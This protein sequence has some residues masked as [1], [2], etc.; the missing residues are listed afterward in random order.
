MFK[1][2]LA[3]LLTLQY[4]GLSVAQQRIFGSLPTENGTHK[5]AITPELSDFVEELMKANDIPGLSLGVVRGDDVEL[6]AWGIKTE[7]GEE[8]AS[9]VSYFRSF[10]RFI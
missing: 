3:A 7:D 10:T 9:D 4:L 1:V 8:T 5:R 2:W 6:A